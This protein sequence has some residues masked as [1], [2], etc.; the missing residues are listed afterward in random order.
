[1]KEGKVSG[2]QYK[3]QWFYGISILGVIAIILG[4]YWYTKTSNFAVRQYI[5]VMNNREFDKVYTA[6][7]TDTVPEGIDKKEVI[8]Y[9]EK[10]FYNNNFVKM[11][12]KGKI[13]EHRDAKG[14]DY[15]EVEYRLRD[16]VI[17]NLL[18][19]K[20]E[21]NN[22][23]VL[24]PF[25]VNDIEIFAPLGAKV[26]V[27]EQLIEESQN[28]VYTCKNK[29]PNRYNIRITYPNN[30]YNDYIT[31]I[32]VPAQTKVVSPYKTVS[33]NVKVPTGMLVTLA[34][35]QLRSED[36]I[37]TFYNILE[38]KYRIKVND[39]YGYIKPYEQEI[40]ISER[41][42]TVEILN[43][44][45]S[46]KCKKQLE[47]FIKTFY[48]DYLNGIR[49]MNSSFLKNYTIGEESKAMF[50][51]WFVTKKQI[52]NASMEITL[53]NIKVNEEGKLEIGILE[54]V[55]LENKEKNKAGNAENITYKVVL[56]TD[57]KINIEEENWK[58]A[59]RKIGESIVAYQ[60][61][62]NNWVEY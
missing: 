9:M 34:D 61:L 11:I 30:I 17:K 16:T 24:F 22:W 53:E 31:T 60:D 15:Y 38:G 54:V 28:G 46:E 62:H 5:D 57:N 6:F 27:D 23:K 12:S 39:A 3:K 50:E 58:I 36:G 19:V 29:L 47:Q 18:S 21:Q 41:K 55:K 26:Y 37:V 43:L 45:P 20:K 2:R 32:E 56:R 49:D 33:V 10:Y 35:Q 52:L 48:G 13:N 8:E 42:N 51:D 1:M 44:N 7:S 4:T 14:L 25:K 40:L 59:D